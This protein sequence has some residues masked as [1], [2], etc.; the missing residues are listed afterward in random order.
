MVCV[1]IY[2]CPQPELV[3]VTCGE[4][5]HNTT[6]WDVHLALMRTNDVPIYPGNLYVSPLDSDFALDWLNDSTLGIYYLAGSYPD[7]RD[8]KTGAVSKRADFQYERQVVGVSVKFIPADPATL[9]AKRVAM[10]AREIRSAAA[11]INKDFPAVGLKSQ[12][13]SFALAPVSSYQD[14]ATLF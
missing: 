1:Q 13:A 11:L 3:L 6:G 2:S 12:T 9:K 5:Y 7:I 8:V 14:K 4:T 10:S